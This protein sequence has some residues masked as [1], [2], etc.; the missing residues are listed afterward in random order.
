MILTHNKQRIYPIMFPI[1]KIIPLICHFVQHFC[2]FQECPFIFALAS[3]LF[4]RAISLFRR[5]DFSISNLEFEFVSKANFVKVVFTF[6]ASTKASDT[7]FSILTPF[8]EQTLNN[9]F[10]F[11]AVAK[12]TNESDPSLFSL[13]SNSRSDGCGNATLFE[14]ASR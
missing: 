5:K 3:F 10:F 4:F 11:K 9:V 6:M 13:M 2:S 14:I 7:V 1:T 12:E 8:I